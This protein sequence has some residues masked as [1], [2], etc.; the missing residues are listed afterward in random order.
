M[1]CQIVLFNKA[2]KQ[3]GLILFEP[4]T[5]AISLDWKQNASQELSSAVTT[6]LKGIQEDK[7]IKARHEVTVKNAENKTIRVQKIET[8]FVTD[9]NFLA[10]LADKINRSAEFKSKLFAVVKKF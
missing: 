6:L 8:V 4:E 7:S 5:R 9:P 3:V 2:R 10:A 1:S